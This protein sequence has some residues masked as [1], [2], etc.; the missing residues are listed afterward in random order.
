MKSRLKINWQTLLVEL[1][2]VFIGVYLAFLLNNFQE[3]Q[4]AKNEEHKVMTSLKKSLM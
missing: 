4:K 3:N 2:V 1:L